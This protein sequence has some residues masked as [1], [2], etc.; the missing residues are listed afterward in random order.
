MLTNP[1]VIRICFAGIFGTNAMHRSPQ[2]CP[3][4]LLGHFIPYLNF[5]T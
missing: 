1:F 5:R 4:G 2:K 3:S